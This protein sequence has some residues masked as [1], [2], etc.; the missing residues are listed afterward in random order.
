MISEPSGADAAVTLARLRAD[1][2]SGRVREIRER[3]RL[4]QSEVAEGVGVERSTVAQWEAGRMP[5]GD[6]AARYAA[7]LARLEA[8]AREKAP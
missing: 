7:L 5:R 8:T 4:S 6:H 1:V 3:A 2:A